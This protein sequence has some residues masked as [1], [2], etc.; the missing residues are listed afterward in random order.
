MK[1]YRKPSL[2]LHSSLLG[3]LLIIL[4]GITVTP[5]PAEAGIRCTNGPYVP[6]N[7]IKSWAQGA[8]VFIDWRA[9][10]CGIPQKKYRINLSDR[11][12]FVNMRRMGYL[13]CFSI[14]QRAHS[15]SP[16]GLA[17]WF[18]Y[19]YQTSKHCGDNAWSFVT[20]R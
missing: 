5:T 12:T 17:S 11:N 7:K 20:S 18:Y 13:H 3:A 15:A 8:L 9:P 10:H 16:A 2:L 14:H 19:Q 1:S 4:A 6:S